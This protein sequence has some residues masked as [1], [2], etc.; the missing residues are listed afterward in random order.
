VRSSPEVPGYAKAYTP[1]DGPSTPAVVIAP[2]AQSSPEHDKPHSATVTSRMRAVRAPAS[3]PIASAPPVA[4]QPFPVSS[5][6]DLDYVVPTRKNGKLVFGVLGGVALLIV[7]FV[8]ARAL[9]GSSAPETSASSTTPSA[10][11]AV[12]AAEAAAVAPPP[13]PAPVETTAA[14]AP[15]PPPPEP[16]APAAPPAK[17]PVEPKANKPKSEPAAS[18]V[19]ARPATRYP[20]VGES[21]QPASKPSKGVIVRDA[22]F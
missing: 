19:P 7:A 8:G 6:D 16:E 20:T 13:T 18:P 1:K 2:E 5:T 14:A 22:P 4:S 10:T 17:A 12:A 15:I 21:S 9:S 3:S 11:A